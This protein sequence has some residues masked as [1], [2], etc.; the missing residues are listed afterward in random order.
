M[1]LPI[2][3]L[4]GLVA[5]TSTVAVARAD[6]VFNWSGFYIGGHA[7]YGFGTLSNTESGMLTDGTLFGIPGTYD[8]AE[9]FSGEDSAFDFDGFFGGAQIGYNAAFDHFLVG[10]ETDLDWS[11]IE[12]SYRLL[13]SADGPTYDS[14]AS[15]DWFGTL[16]ARLG[17]TA[18]RLLFY[19]TAGLAYGGGSAD[20]TVTPGVPGNFAGDPFSASASRTHWGYAVG[21]G[22]EAALTQRVT[23]RL[24]YLYI[25]LGKQDYVFEFPDSNGSVVYGT[26]SISENMIRAGLNYRF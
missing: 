25:D 6:D 12:T 23:V 22:I 20:L 3:A 14:E 16:R 19:V 13:G 17:V 7:G 21:A 8:P 24:E 10:I 2:A 18:D 1:R 11:G 26:S 15:L 5:V 4:A 9:Y